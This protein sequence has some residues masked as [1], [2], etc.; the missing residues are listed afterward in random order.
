MRDAVI[1]VNL[2]ETYTERTWLIM[3]NFVNLDSFQYDYLCEQ[4][5][6]EVNTKK[7]HRKCLS[8]KDT[9]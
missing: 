7:F 3:N 1:K 8:L 4:I 5:L 2:L 6:L 9:P